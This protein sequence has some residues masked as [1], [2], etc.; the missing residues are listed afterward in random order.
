MDGHD[1]DRGRDGYPRP[2]SAKPWG[3]NDVYREGCP[4][5]GRK[6]PGSSVVENIIFKLIPCHRRAM[7]RALHRASFGRW[8][9]SSPLPAF[10]EHYSGLDGCTSRRVRGIAG[11]EHASLVAASRGDPSFK[12]FRRIVS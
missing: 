7:P 5:Y 12:Q 6:L 2:L 8:Q 3:F 10:G 11:R 1:G 9:S 4:I